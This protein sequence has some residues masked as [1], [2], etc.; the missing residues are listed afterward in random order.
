[1]KHQLQL[2]AL[3]FQ[4]R[5]L[6]ATFLPCFEIVSVPRPEFHERLIQ[7][8]GIEERNERATEDVEDT[9]ASFPGQEGN[10]AENGGKRRKA[11]ALV[12]A[13]KGIRGVRFFTDDLDA[14][15]R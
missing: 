5:F 8:R 9:A 13:N 6:F 3:N 14:Q 2:A 12:P 7:D 15:R 11:D 4:Q 10:G 1:M